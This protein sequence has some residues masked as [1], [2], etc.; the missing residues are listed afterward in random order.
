MP[1]PSAPRPSA[2][3]PPHHAA[4]ERAYLSALL[5]T[6]E[7]DESYL[8]LQPGDFY[9]DTHRQVFEAYCMLRSSHIPIDLGSVAMALRGMGRTDAES[10]VAGLYADELGVVSS[11][12][13]FIDT[14]I[15][16]SVQRDL[17][18]L[19]HVLT[20]GHAPALDD[21]AARLD[22]LR[23]R[24]VPPSKQVLA[25]AAAALLAQPFALEPDWL[26]R[27]LF[28]RSSNGWLSGAPKIGK[29]YLALDLAVR[30]IQGRP[31]MGQFAIPRP[32]RVVLVEEEDPP[33]LLQT[34]LHGLLAGEEIQSG[35]WLT[36]RRGLRL[37]N[38]ILMERFT[39]ECRELQVDFTIW[40][41]FSNLHDAD[42]MRGHELRPIL[43][44]L[45]R[46]RD[47][48]GSS[49]LVLHHGRKPGPGGP[50]LASGGQRLRGPGLLHAWAECSLYL[51]GGKGKL[52]IE[53]ECKQ[54]SGEPLDDFNA[55]L[56]T[57]GY[58]YD[59]PA[60]A[61]VSKTDDHRRAVLRLLTD[62]GPGD[63]FTLRAI[64]AQVKLSDRLVANAC[65]ALEQAGAITSCAVAKGSRERRYVI[66]E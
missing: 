63:G 8:R 6:A 17:F 20:N 24:M 36:V 23:A 41:V 7:A 13:S 32:L 52:T 47:T 57:A 49:N 55:H 26:V 50:D 54:Q 60:A 35:L 10:A 15:G 27:S 2:E 5:L 42:E 64:A 51:R 12:D 9:L 43:E 28:V 65:R 33:H 4:A 61:K 46:F 21:V 38:R 3:I 40:D 29:S 62:A 45:T 34:R 53:P 18:Q 48:V 44:T 25:M 11:V 58:V 14:L 56:T 37:D 59:G 22:A 30:M 19:G 39:A 16:F 1:T 31:W 66:A